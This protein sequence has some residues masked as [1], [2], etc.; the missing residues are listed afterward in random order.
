MVAGESR[1]ERAVI[2]TVDANRHAY[3]VLTASGTSMTVGRLKTHPGDNALLEV[4]TPVRID[5]SLGEPIIDGILP[6]EVPLTNE[7]RSTITGTSGHG[8]EDSVLNRNL[9]A[10][11]RGPG[12]ALD[13]IPGDQSIRSP[14]GATI[15]ALH[16]KVA[17]MYGSPMAQVRAFGT[18]D[19]LEL[20]GGVMRF[21]TWMGEAKYINEGGK[22]SYVWRGGSDQLTQT[23]ADEERYTIRLDVGER[24]NLFKF[25]ITTPDN[26][27]LFRFH[28]DP[29]GRLTIMS[30]DGVHHLS[31]R[32]TSSRHA[33]QV[34]GAREVVTEGAK[35]ERVAADTT[36]TFEGNHQTT[37][38]GNRDTID[39]NNRSMR[40]NQQFSV[41]VGG[42]EAHNVGADRLTTINGNDTRQ[43]QGDDETGVVGSST[44]I[45]DRYNIYAAHMK[46][47][48][49][50]TSA[51]VK[52]EELEATLRS[53]VNDFNQFKLMVKTHS[54]PSNGIPAPTLSALIGFILNLTRAKSTILKIE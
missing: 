48:R 13:V 8:A 23:G 7:A 51:A 42:R 36:E 19:T 52:Y 2:L 50:A 22:T 37:V 41:S 30:A 40:V 33:D 18:T 44:N 34:H 35:T 26:Q 46:V 49:N 24:G 29:H 21:V 1:R 28:V 45:A 15:G 20:I 3:R 4:H 27:P 53:L 11:F 14:D 32:G 38:S 12:E 16:G 5:Y 17:Q 43:V 39:M 10:T 25:E 47:G 54:H 31:G 6:V 9:G